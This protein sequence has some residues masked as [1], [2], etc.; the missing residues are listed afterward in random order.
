MKKIVFSF[1][2]IVVIFSNLRAQPL[3][4]FVDNW[5]LNINA[6]PT[7]FQ[8]DITQHYEWYKMDISNPK[9]SFGINLIKDF[10]CAFSGRYQL[11]YGW[12][13]GKKDFYRDGTPANLSFKAHFYH[14]NAQLKINILDL[15]AP[16]KCSRKCNLY[17][18]AGLGFIN[19][20]TRLYRNGEEVLSWGYG[21]SG[22]YR[23]V[24]EVTV[25]YGLG[26]DLRLGNKWRINFDVEVIPVDNEKLDRITGRYEHDTFIYPNF[27][28][29]YNISKYNK[30]CCNR[31]VNNP[32]INF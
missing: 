17:G 11:G 15:F 8:G 12:L 25:P 23:W 1:G 2:L 9:A 21:R 28:V 14:F 27:G 31:R 30:L 18:F 22:T 7:I 29:T 6:G 19:F 13:A 16:G 24:T 10:T 26:V 5:Y 4:P 20:Q 3:I 32:Q